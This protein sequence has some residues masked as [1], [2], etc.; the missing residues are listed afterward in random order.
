MV[1]GLPLAPPRR[2]RFRR[3][4]AGRADPADAPAGLVRARLDPVR[5][6]SFDLYTR[7]ALWAASQALPGEAKHLTGHHGTGVLVLTGDQIAI[8]DPMVRQH[9][10]DPGAGLVQ[11]ALTAEFGLGMLRC[12]GDTEVTH[13]PIADSGYMPALNQRPALAA[14][15]LISPSGPWQTPPMILSAALASVILMASG[16]EKPRSN[17][18][19]QPPA[20]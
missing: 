12:V 8:D 16:S 14:V 6:G 7:R 20:R 5:S 9:I 1:V 4:V 15:A 11:R 18:A 2:R 13:L 17:A 3:G 10:G 19:P